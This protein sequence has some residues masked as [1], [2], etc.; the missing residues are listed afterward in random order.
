M[1]ACLKAGAGNNE[2]DGNVISSLVKPR[3]R[4]PDRSWIA[5]AIEYLDYRLR[6]LTRRKRS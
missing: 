3:R 6:M 5:K 2:R 1:T 4:A